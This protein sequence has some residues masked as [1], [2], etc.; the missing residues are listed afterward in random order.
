[1]Q[2][3]VTKLQLLH[4]CLKENKGFTFCLWIDKQLFLTSLLLPQH[5]AYCRKRHTW[6][7]RPKDPGP[8]SQ[9]ALPGPLNVWPKHLFRPSTGCR[10]WVQ[11]DPVLGPQP[12]GGHEAP[13]THSVW[14][15]VS[16]AHTRYAHTWCVTRH[17]NS[18]RYQVPT[19]CDTEH[20]TL[21]RYRAG[22]HV[23]NSRRTPRTHRAASPHDL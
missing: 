6:V 12:T 11:Q 19:T 22:F 15:R 23:C 1:M 8:K 4:F 18:T 21:T 14:P 9:R 3:T 2:P 20:Q 16:H 13:W 5:S 7:S 10:L 17:G